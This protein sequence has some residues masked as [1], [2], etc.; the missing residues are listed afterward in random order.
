MGALGRAAYWALLGGATLYGL[1][2]VAL[3]ALWQIMPEGRW[4]VTVSNIFALY[5]FLPLLLLAPLALAIPSRWLRGVVAA[6]LLICAVSFGPWLVPPMAPPPEGRPLRVVTFNQRIIAAR[7][8]E[9]LEAVK[10][11][12]ADVVALQEVTPDVIRE[13][14]VQLGDTFPHQVYSPREL[15]HNLLILSRFP[16]REQPVDPNVRRLWVTLDVDGQPVNLINLHFSSPDYGALSIP[17]PVRI[18][19]PRGYDASF[20]AREAPRILADIDSISGPLIV[21]GDHNTSEREPLYREFAARL[22][23]AFRATSWGTGATYPSN[24]V[25]FGLPLPFPLVRIDYV[26]TRGG[27]APAATHVHCNVAKSD[28]CMVVADLVL[29]G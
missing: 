20:R 2:I 22:T 17:G 16:L 12:N 4:W 7:W 5:L 10:A 14:Y 21:V 8:P 13:A 23:D 29:E 19:M 28:H 18:S 9:I 3:A 27:V 6:P 25:Y 26:W 15:Q 1:G 24:R 11:Q